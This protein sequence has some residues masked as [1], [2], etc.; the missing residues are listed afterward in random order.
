MSSKNESKKDKI[1]K[2]DSAMVLQENISNIGHL[3][4]LNVLNMQKI[5][6]NKNDYKYEDDQIF[7]KMKF[8]PKDI[9]L[10]FKYLLCNKW[11]NSPL[12]L[13]D[14]IQ[15]KLISVE[16]LFQTHLF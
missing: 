5:D 11:N 7:G 15:K 10:F 3:N 6:A 4:S 12:L 13:F 8:S 9:I 14:S 2:K 16:H 1:I